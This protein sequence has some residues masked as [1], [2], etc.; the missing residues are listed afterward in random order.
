MINK[1]YDFDIFYK[2]LETIPELAEYLPSFKQMVYDL[3]SYN[4]KL[5][6]F[7][8][9]E[10]LWDDNIRTILSLI[11]PYIGNKDCL[12]LNVRW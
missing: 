9:D 7:Y 2:Q 11:R 5:I 3:A 1:H 12:V 10:I 6:Y 4:G 8:F